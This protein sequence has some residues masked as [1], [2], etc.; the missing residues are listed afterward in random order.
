MTRLVPNNG[1]RVADAS[2][3]S[4]SYAMVATAVPVSW[5]GSSPRQSLKDFSV[6]SFKIGGVFD[7]AYQLVTE[8]FSRFKCSKHELRQFSSA[9][10]VSAGANAVVADGVAQLSRNSVRYGS[11]A[12]RPGLSETR[13]DRRKPANG[14]S[15][16]AQNASAMMYAGQEN[17]LVVA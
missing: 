7:H 3:G 17:Q 6:R 1:P 5:R 14:I 4:N 16:H 12:L 2:R 11:R 8:R 10:A 15:A 9:M 13:D